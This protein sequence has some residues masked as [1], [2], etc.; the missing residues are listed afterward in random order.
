[1]DF[2]QSNNNLLCAN[3]N[4]EQDCIIFGT[5]KGLYVYTLYP[6]KKII[7]RKIDGGVS[8]V[9]MLHRS[10]IIFFVGTLENGPNS[11]Q[12]LNIWDDSHKNIVGQIDFKDTIEHIHTTSDYI[13]VSTKDTIFIY[14]FDN[15]QQIHSISIEHTNSSLFKVKVDKHLLIYP[16]YNKMILYNW[17]TK[18]SKTIDCHIHTIELFSLSQDHSLLATCSQ[19]G[20]LLRIF[21]IDTLQQ[22]K[23]LRRGSDHVTIVNIAFNNDATLLLCSSNKGTI[24]IFSLSDTNKQPLLHTDETIEIQDET[25]KTVI[26]DTPKDTTDT[27]S[28][29]Q[30]LSEDTNNTTTIQNKKMYGTHYFKSFLPNYFNSEWSFIQIYLNHSITYSVF[31]KQTNNIIT[32]ASN[33]CFYSIEFLYDSK[34]QQSSYKI[35]STLKFLSDHNDPFDNRTSTI[36]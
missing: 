3:V 22:V 13:F 7:S 14:S 25:E 19:K 6:Q 29:E 35:V 11:K 34:S 10:N 26:E 21:N 24:H 36:L 9:S 32:I 23:E 33:G 15:L 30:S 28:K 16:S 4:E 1:M 31:S 2:S 20:S 18:E 5:K 8:K 27:Q 12:M 17:E